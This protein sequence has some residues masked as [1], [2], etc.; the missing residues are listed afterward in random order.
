MTQ[1]ALSGAPHKHLDDDGPANA[2]DVRR[3]RRAIAGDRVV[4]RG[5]ERDPAGS[6]RS[7]ARRSSSTCRPPERGPRVAGPWRDLAAWQLLSTDGEDRRATGR[8]SWSESSL[9]EPRR[10]RYPAAVPARPEVTAWVSSCGRAGSPST[11]RSSTRSPRTTSGG[12][13]A[14]PSG[15]TSPRRGRCSPATTSRTLPGRLGFYDLRLPESARGA[16]R[17]S[18]RS[19][20]SRRSATG[21]TGSAAGGGSS[22]GRSPRCSIAA[23]PTSRSASAGR[24]RPGRGIWHG[25]ADRVLIEQT[26]PGPDDDQAPLRRVA[27]GV[28][29]PRAT[30]AS[31]AG[32]CSTSSDPSSCPTPRRSSTGGRRMAR[33]GRARGLYLVAEISDLLGHGPKYPTRDATASTPASTSA[34]RRSRRAADAV[35]MRAA[36]QAASR[37]PS[38]TPT[39]ETRLQLTAG[40]DQPS[41]YPCVY[42]NWDNTPRS[43]RRGLVHHGSSPERFQPHVQAAVELARRPARRASGC[44]SS[45]RGTSGPRATTSSPTSST[46]T[47]SS[48]RSPTRVSTS[49]SA[50]SRRCG[51][52]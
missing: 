5:H 13:R 30:S 26:Y 11:C 45:S 25:A 22:S 33:A 36:A 47:A 29:R 16:G 17:R 44:S 49:E 4:P 41:Y 18:R 8:R 27:A 51:S 38:A 14:S 21:T 32:R 24:T 46:A 48:R 52:R 28:P 43:G 15:R 10:Q 34:C 19:T 20:A 3:G 2:A 7:E 1:R 42:P 23:S 39:P 35:A 9:R 6:G 37:G 50:P 40:A 31:T 12:G